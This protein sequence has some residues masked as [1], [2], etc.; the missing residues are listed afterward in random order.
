MY[1]PVKKR[2]PTDHKN[3]RRHR[4]PGN[5]LAQHREE[6]MSAGGHPMQ[7]HK[8]YNVPSSDLLGFLWEGEGNE[9]EEE[10]EE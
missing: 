6:R 7:K 10:E 4:S 8:L 1:I 5:V 2:I 9:G 3:Y